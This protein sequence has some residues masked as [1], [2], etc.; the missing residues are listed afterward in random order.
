MKLM[1]GKPDDTAIAL[2]EKIGDVWK[3]SPSLTS[4]MAG[5]LKEADPEQFELWVEELEDA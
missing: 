2:A 3:P 4:D 5:F 1:L